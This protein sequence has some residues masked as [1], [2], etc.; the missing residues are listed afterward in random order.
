MTMIW[1]LI[2]TGADMKKILIICVC[3][4][5][6]SCQAMKEKIWPAVQEAGQAYSEFN[7][8]Y[9]AESNEAFRYRL[10]AGIR[11][12]APQYPEDGY[13]GIREIIIGANRHE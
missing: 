13:C 10:L 2:I 1:F 9:C 12:V 7:E 6:V 5:L 11:I 3:L 8:R 4:L